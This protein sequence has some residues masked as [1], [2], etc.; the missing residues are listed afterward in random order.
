MNEPTKQHGDSYAA[1]ERE[2][3]VRYQGFKQ[4]LLNPLLIL[5][6]RMGVQPWMITG[7]SLVTGLAFCPLFLMADTGWSLH[8]AYVMLLLHLLLDGLDGPLALTPALS[9]PWG[10]TPHLQ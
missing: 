10:S 4:R 2:A 3:M 5:L 6:E 1:S 8:S 9:T 7:A